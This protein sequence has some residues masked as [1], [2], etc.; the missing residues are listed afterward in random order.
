MEVS[1]QDPLRSP[2]SYIDSYVPSNRHEFEVAETTD[3]FVEGAVWVSNMLHSRDSLRMFI[4]QISSRLKQDKISIWMKGPRPLRWQLVATSGLSQMEWGMFQSGKVSGSEET[5]CWV[6]WLEE[7]EESGRLPDLT[8]LPENWQTL[9]VIPLFNHERRIVGGMMLPEIQE[10]PEREDGQIASMPVLNMI[11]TLLHD[12]RRFL[13]LKRQGDFSLAMNRISARLI[14]AQD[15][16]FKQELESVFG[17]IASE[18]GAD[19]IFLLELGEEDQA[20]LYNRYE[21]RA[22]GMPSAKPVFQGL[23]RNHFVIMSPVVDQARTAHVVH[24]HKLPDTYDRR[25]MEAIQVK[26]FVA[27]P[28]V[29][30][31]KVVGYLS[32]ENI[33]HVREW[34]DD[35]LD[36]ILMATELV[37]FGWMRHRSQLY[38]R[39][40]QKQTQHLLEANNRLDFA[41]DYESV[42][43]AMYAAIE[44]C[45]GYKSIWLLIL[46]KDRKHLQVAGAKGVQKP[47][48]VT[49]PRDFEIEEDDVLKKIL[50]SEE[51]IE[52]RDIQNLPDKARAKAELFRLRSFVHVP[53][54]ILGDTLGLIGAGA[55]ANQE[56][57]RLNDL[58]VQFLRQLGQYASVALD[59]ITF[60]KKQKEIEASLLDTK[61]GLEREVEARTRELINS[62]K[63]LERFAYLASHDLQEPLRMVISYLQLLETRVEDR[64]TDVDREFLDYAVE[65]AKRMKELLDGILA[66]SR[67]NRKAD[68]FVPVELN[69]VMDFV[70]SNLEMLIQT[71]NG[72]VHVSELPEVLADPN[73]MIQ[74]FQNLVSNGLKFSSPDTLSPTVIVRAEIEGDFAIVE[75]KDNG[76]GIPSK[77]EARIF[78]MFQ[79]L[80]TRNEYP[81]NGVGLSI[82]REI[83][84]RH[85]GKIWV[86]S[87]EGEG[88]SFFVKLPLCQVPDLDSVDS[89]GVSS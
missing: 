48:G 36:F 12:A 32:V 71:K 52:I 14:N 31:D 80:H 33:H 10:L 4:G 37:T 66:Y 51:V 62:N 29:L 40:R 18:I 39:A 17:L 19:R 53:I 41:T 7:W 88:A 21:W 63:S 78:E 75:V 65:G 67:V 47:H 56:P 49:P 86:E 24:V 1:S 81:G 45:T 82:C 42:L 35:E 55:F 20:L 72:Q 60:R 74:I 22:A 25:I 11:G 84:N 77:Y 73:Q 23:N 85:G 34:E 46:S 44:A 68:P 2:W 8:L 83:A 6:D 13:Y 76:I 43:S 27:V 15:R 5:I 70:I 26:S 87:V 3:T 30:G 64:L 9:R 50:S 16:N 54:Q 58:Q 57:V 59:R 79:R 89:E 61:M 38:Q 69:K 28:L